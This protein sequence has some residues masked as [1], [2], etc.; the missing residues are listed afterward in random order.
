[1]YI[2]Y[3]VNFVWKEVIFDNEFEYDFKSTAIKKTKQK[4]CSN[5]FKT[6]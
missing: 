2:I 3:S 4:L 1:M 6:I 5:S